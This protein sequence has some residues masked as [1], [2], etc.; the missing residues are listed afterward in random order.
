MRTW[1]PELTWQVASAVVAD[2]SERSVQAPNPCVAGSAR[3]AT[4]H[5]TPVRY[6]SPTDELTPCMRPRI[7]IMAASRAGRVFGKALITRV[8]ACADAAPARGCPSAA[9]KLSGDT[10]LYK[11]NTR[12]AAKSGSTWRLSTVHSELAS[13]K[14]CPR[15]TGGCLQADGIGQ[16]RQGKPL[17]A[18]T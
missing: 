7:E 6:G 9:Q 8:S 10:R 2:V 16:A 3:L 14:R 1:A 4:G 11:D 12:G 17:G 18:K 15:D 13:S 5:L